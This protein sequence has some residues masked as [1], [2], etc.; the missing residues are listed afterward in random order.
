[1]FWKI[2]LARR[3]YEWV[4]PAPDREQMRY[5]IKGWALEFAHDFDQQ[6]SGPV[7]GLS[8]RLGG[9]GAT[10]AASC[11]TGGFCVRVEGGW[12]SGGVYTHWSLL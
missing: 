9:S 2:P 7:V 1:M 8:K 6:A 3:L 10:L 12:W 11:D 4:I 5:N